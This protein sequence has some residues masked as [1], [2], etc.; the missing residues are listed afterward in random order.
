MPSLPHPSNLP[1]AQSYPSCPVQYNPPTAF[2]QRRVILTSPP[3]EHTAQEVAMGVNDSHSPARRPQVTEH[4]ASSQSLS[5]GSPSDGALAKPHKGSSRAS[6]KAHPVGHSRAPHGRLPSYGKGLHKL[7]KLGPGNTTEGVGH[8]RGHTR[9]ASHTPSTSPTTPEFKRTSS[10]VSLPRTG[11]KVSFK[12][13]H[14]HVSLSRNGSTTKLGSQVKPDKAR[15][16]GKMRRKGTDDTPLK[17]TANFQVGEEA[18]DDEWTEDSSSPYTTRQNSAAP[19]RPKTPISRDPPSP[20]HS[21]DDAPQRSPTNFP[22][23][24]PES[25]HPDASEMGLH[26]AK[27]RPQ[28][29]GNHQERNPSNYSQPPDAE[30]VT[31]RLLNRNPSHTPL[32][33]TSTVSANIT[34]PRAGSRT[35]SFNYGSSQTLVKDPSLP[36]NGISRFLDGTGSGPGSATP[37]SVSHLQSNLAHLDRNSFARQ[38]YAHPAAR[39]HADNSSANRKSK[40]NKTP[41]S[42][43]VKS[44]ADLTH[45]H[46]SPSFPEEPTSPTSSPTTSSDSKPH[47]PAP[48]PF[49]SA[50]GADPSAGKSLTQL[51]LDLQRLSAQRLDQPGQPNNSPLL[52]HGYGGMLNTAG[53]RGGETD[54]AARVGRQWEFARRE[55]EGGKRFWPETVRGSVVESRRG[56]EA[57]RKQRAKVKTVVGSQGSQETARGRVRFEVGG[58]SFED[59]SANGSGD[60]EE[61][62]M[63][64]DVLEGLVRRMWVSGEVAAGE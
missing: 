27:V 48:S 30:A 32:S 61:E 9:S 10:N 64:D 44:A 17:G 31:N 42:R 57:G 12:K 7:S 20:D 43:R 62:A 22:H 54:M 1:P 26:P 36:A 56:D 5:R 3:E 37:G 29:N 13:N 60:G 40:A 16:E 25:P 11:S 23:S 41:D 34:P 39:P 46:L 55:V 38:H 6:H 19:S 4:S 63:G 24:P 52:N 8:T 58:R 59:G 49:E 45:T 47:K 15:T 35:S 53:L 50:R 51:K 33:Q 21:T 14:S 28:T 18:H 2:G